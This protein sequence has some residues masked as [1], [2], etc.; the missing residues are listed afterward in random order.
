MV[1]ACPS[2]FDIQLGIIVRTCSGSF[3][4]PVGMGSFLCVSALK[5]SVFFTAVF[6]APLVT[7]A[8]P[9]RAE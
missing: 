6:A 9:E 3:V 8:V 2:M 4:V 5:V 7:V 1:S